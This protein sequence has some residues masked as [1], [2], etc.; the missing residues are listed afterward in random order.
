MAESHTSGTA[1][2]NVPTPELQ[3]C[4]TLWRSLLESS[5]DAVLILQDG[6]VIEHNARVL[7][8]FA[9]TREHLAEHTPF[10]WSPE[11]QPDGRLS[12]DVI[13]AKLHAAL[14]GAPQFF[15]W[16]HVRQDGAQ[17]ISDVSVHS[18]TLEGHLYLQ[19]VL[20]DVT[21]QYNTS[22]QISASQQERTAILSNML[23]TYFQADKYG[24][25]TFISPSVKQLLG[26][27]S[28]NII[29][30]N[31]GEIY[32][33]HVSRR[34]FMRDLAR[35]RGVLIDYEIQLRRHDRALVWVSLNVR[36]CRDGR[37]KAVGFEG[38]LRDI[39]ERK[40]AEAELRKLS[41]MLLQ[42]ADSVL[43]TNGEGLVE[44]VNPSFEAATGY[45]ASEVV[46][47]RHWLVR[48]ER[49][50]GA[51]FEWVWKTIAAGHVFRD[52]FATRRKDGALIYED[53]TITPVRDDTGHITHYIATGK[54]ITDRMQMQSRLRYPAHHDV[55]TDLPN[56][57][58]F[59][60]RLTHAV[61]RKK[62]N[63]GLLAVLAIDLDRFKTVNVSYSPHV[64]DQ[65]LQAISERLKH[66]VREADTV[67]R[68]DG[69]EFAVILEE[70]R[71]PDHIA[72][73]ARKVLNVLAQP[74]E[75]ADKQLHLT[76]NVGISVYPSDGDD[77]ASLLK[78]ANIAMYRAREQGRNT[79]QFYSADASAKAFERLSLESSLRFAL[80]HNELLLHYQPIVDIRK[81]RIVGMEALLRWQHRDLG[82][83]TPADFLPT[84]EDSELIVPIGEWI[85]RTACQQAVAWQ[86][87]GFGPFPISVNLT[88]S[89]FGLPSLRQMLQQVLHETRLEPRWLELEF[90]ESSLVEHPRANVF[91]F[92]ELDS[93]GVRL[94]IDD[95]GA[96]ISSVSYL[97]RLPIDALKIDRTF[98]ADVVR[99]ADDQAVVRASLALAKALELRAI[100]K[101]VEREDQMRF[102]AMLGCDIMQ[103]YLFS[104]PRPAEQCAILLQ[105]GPT[106][107][108][109]H[110]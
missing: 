87:S 108:D 71:S 76:V 16:Y 100:A 14:Q 59:T 110:L 72:P 78:H 15:G 41:S 89:Q 48:A 70:L 49:K 8:M 12:A 66:C 92:K 44:Y 9:C 97:A 32:V 6:K 34:H 45:A 4:Q 19:A 82:L 52:V 90:F 86:R 62:E 98:I 99:D 27:K 53:R 7:A 5:N 31:I 77:A 23:D 103:G 96:G 88:M 20:R 68:V 85:V 83:V 101:G 65:V 46:G 63:P 35:R 94:A 30:L 21:E 75:I 73:I 69:D 11:R 74:F 51:Y 29:G 28:D 3:R 79:F 58:L 36:V 38:T 109:F 61:E 25:L 80:E 107:P 55:L 104:A 2:N 18:L 22:Q 57:S 47:T 64:G 33:D 95:F 54:D 50:D 10:D 43:V 40:K 105:Q 67:A 91:T 13:A 60:D 1:G 81:R 24:F 102:L 37:G 106:F 93:L 17:V 42:T 39:T 56:V 26:F 84:L